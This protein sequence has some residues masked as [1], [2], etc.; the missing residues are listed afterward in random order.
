MVA[1]KVE[2]RNCPKHSL[3]KFLY[4][5]A[6]T[7]RVGHIREPP[8]DDLDLCALEL[9]CQ[10]WRVALFALDGLFSEGG[11]ELSQL[12]ELAPGS[13]THDTI[14]ND[15]ACALVQLILQLGAWPDA[16]FAL[17]LDFGG[18]HVSVE[19]QEFQMQSVPQVE[20]KPVAVHSAQ[21]RWVCLDSQV[22]LMCEDRSA[23]I[24]MRAKIRIDMVDWCQ[25]EW[26]SGEAGVTAVSCVEVPLEEIHLD[27]RLA[28]TFQAC[29]KKTT[30]TEFLGPRRGQILKFQH[31]ASTHSGAGEKVTHNINVVGK[32]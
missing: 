18:C 14:V 12:V 27:P 2:V 16:I 6:A 29:K 22:I 20:L 24:C 9:S 32:N 21:R 28:I 1:Y 13:Q 7:N 4:P 15:I 8:H 5:R 31:Q 3:P 30:T 19:A 23:P 11:A 25:W 26:L 10:L 17:R